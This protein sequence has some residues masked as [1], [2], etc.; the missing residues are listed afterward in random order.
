MKDNQT[1]IDKLLHLLETYQPNTLTESD[2]LAITNYYSLVQDLFYQ[3]DKSEWSLMDSYKFITLYN[4]GPSKF[5][6]FMEELF[7]VRFPYTHFQNGCAGA[8]QFIQ[9]LSKSPKFNKSQL[10]TPKFRI[11]DSEHYEKL[12]KDLRNLKVE[13]LPDISHRE[14]TKFI[15]NNFNTGKAASTFRKDY[16]GPRKK[17]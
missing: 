11:K 15:S 5:I 8:F 14:W 9:R 17:E 3:F 12:L 1:K 4:I 6:N 16:T 2:D 7:K 13:F 10:D